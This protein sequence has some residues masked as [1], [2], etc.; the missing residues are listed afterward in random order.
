MA[1]TIDNKAEDSAKI[2]KTFEEKKKYYLNG[3]KQLSE[4]RNNLPPHE[5]KY[6]PLYNEK[7]AEKEAEAMAKGEFKYISLH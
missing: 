7:E 6:I 3:L 2:P 5:K 4:K 1:K